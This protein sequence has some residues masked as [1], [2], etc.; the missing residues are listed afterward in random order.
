MSA[1]EDVV[2]LA[3]DQWGL[4]TTAQAEKLGVHRHRLASAVSSGRME[5]IAHGVYAMA[6]VPDSPLTRLRAAYLGA[7]AA[8]TLAERKRRLP[9][10]GVVS[11]T[12]AAVVHG[13]G[14]L[15][16]LRH[17]MTF[18]VRR[19]TQRRDIKYHL[20]KIGPESITEVDRLPV[21]TVE[22]TAADLLRSGVDEDH[23]ALV[24]SDAEDRALLDR[25]A[26]LKELAPVAHARGYDLDAWALRL[27]PAPNLADVLAK[28][29]AG[30]IP[31][32]YL[33]RLNG[34]GDPMVA[35]RL[36]EAGNAARRALEDLAIDT[37]MPVA[38][39]VAPM[40][41][42]GGLTT[43]DAQRVEPDDD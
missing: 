22:R 6:G 19:Q 28:R 41:A 10:S 42:A 40:L 23:V 27:A 1:L 12:S 18:P 7:D 38:D 14:T 39:L 21:T 4:V 35:V 34:L 33:T 31:K 8:A 20:M 3:A 37:G 5:R 13:L 2:D 26:L 43:T 16:A 36:R 30:T 29:L 25:N 11:H 9:D 17:E 32:D 15:R 24:L